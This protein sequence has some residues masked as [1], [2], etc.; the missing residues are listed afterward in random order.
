[1]KITLLSTSDSGGAGIAALRLH[2]GLMALA[3]NSSFLSRYEQHPGS[4]THKY[5]FNEQRGPS[6]LNRIMRKLGLPITQEEK[7]KAALNGKTGSYEIFSFPQSNF[8]VE[9]HAAVQQADI[10]N[11]H[12]AA[13]FINYPT[14]LAIPKPMVF[15]LHDCNAFMGGFHYPEDKERNKATLGALDQELEL[16]KQKAFSQRKAKTAIVSPSAWLGKLAQQSEVFKNLDVHV[17]PNSINTHVFRPYDKHFARSVFNIPTD[18]KVVLYVSEHIRNH[19]KGFDLLTDAL[20][21]VDSNNTVL[22]ATGNANASAHENIIY[23]GSIPDE[24][25]MA[26]LYSAADVFVLP[27]REDNLPNVALE[28]IACG[29]PVIAFNIGGIPEIITTGFNGILAQSLSATDLAQA[30]NQFLRGDSTFNADAI[31]ADAVKRFDTPVQATAY[32]RLYDQ[33]RN[34]S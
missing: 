7:N 25:L 2:K 32:A 23:T 1:M 6:F 30:I 24:R 8:R 21:Q 31:R 14:F 16:I 15:T 33:L 3:V 17:I 22:V 27:S 9:Q 20:Q 18:K 19:R 11:V 5:V 10:I 29:T 28:S 34:N 12:W 26:L 4:A 13:G